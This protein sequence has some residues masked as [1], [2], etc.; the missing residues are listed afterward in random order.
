M[1]G[2]RLNSEG[3][4]TVFLV[5]FGLAIFATAARLS[6]A[7]TAG[8]DEDLVKQT[9]NPVANLISVPFQSNFN[10]DTGKTD[11]MV[12]VLNIQP[13]IPISLTEDW[14][15]ITRTIMPPSTSRIRPRR[16]GQF[17]SA[18]STQHLLVAGGLRSSGAPARASS[19]LL[20]SGAGRRPCRRS[21]HG[22]PVVYTRQPSVGFRRGT[23]RTTFC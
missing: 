3:K 15:L 9:Q 23:D 5:A 2:V 20:G 14:N 7:E 18:T 19:H 10:F 16:R 6:A 4:I 22:R 12:Y 17:G 8:S 13:V 1:G 21:L 11:K